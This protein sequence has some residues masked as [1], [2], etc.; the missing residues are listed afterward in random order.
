MVSRMGMRRR[1]L[2]TF[3]ARGLQK[4]G[5]GSTA[6][7]FIDYAR[8]TGHDLETIKKRSERYGVL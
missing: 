8:R 3:A 7:T 1:V 5:S 2:D 4:Q 6:H